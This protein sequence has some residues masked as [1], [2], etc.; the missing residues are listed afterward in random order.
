MGIELQ[1]HHIGIIPQVPLVQDPLI[2][3]SLSD[4][5]ATAMAGS[6]ILQAPGQN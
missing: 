1:I 5:R 6:N 3:R 2:F 4:R